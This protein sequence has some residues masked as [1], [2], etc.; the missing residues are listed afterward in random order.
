MKF[1]ID[2]EIELKETS[3]SLNGR[4]YVDALKEMIQNKPHDKPFTI[5]LFGEWG[6]GKSSIIKTVKTE[7][8]LDEKTKFITF[9]AWKYEDDAFRRSFILTLYDQLG[10]EVDPY[11]I[12]LYGHV[13]E[14]IETF[15]LKMPISVWLL[16]F[17][18]LVVSICLFVYN[19]SAAE[20]LNSL[21][22][23][24]IIL[25]YTANFG[26]L[27]KWVL[28]KKIIGEAISLLRQALLRKYKE[29]RPLFFSPEQF[30]GAFQKA[31]EKSKDRFN[32]IVVVV[33]NL[34]R[35]ERRYS[36]ELLGTIRGFLEDRNV[37]FV[38]PVD[39]NA[40]KKHIK[41]SFNEND[42]EA[43]EFLRKFFSVTLRIKP[44]K[45]QEIY[46]F[47]KGINRKHA[48]GFS[49]LTI[50][51]VSKEY[52]SNPRRIIQM[53]NNLSTEL[54]LFDEEFR[55]KFETVICKFLIIREEFPDYY[56]CLQRNPH[57]LLV[58][59]NE[60]LKL[61]GKPADDEL[62]G[63]INKT[64]V[65]TENVLI[66][67]ISRI[68][69]NSNVFATIPTDVVKYID[70]LRI[71]DLNS[72]IDSN[73][74]GAELIV[75]YIIAEMADHRDRNLLEYKFLNLLDVI[76]ELDERWKFSFSQNSRIEEILK[77]ILLHIINVRSSISKLANYGTSITSQGKRYIVDG[78]VK[79]INSE[80]ISGGLSDK[81][82]EVLLILLDTHRN[83]EDMFKQ[84]KDP[85]QHMY[86]INPSIVKTNT[87]NG[88]QLRIFFDTALI[89]FVIQSM[90]SLDEDDIS[91]IHYRDIV[92]K[93]DVAISL[94][95]QFL[96]KVE[97]LFPSFQNL[98]FDV[99][100]HTQRKINNAIDL[101]SGNLSGEEDTLRALSRRYDDNIEV[102][103]PY[104]TDQRVS[105]NYLQYTLDNQDGMEEILEFA[106]QIYRLSSGNVDMYDV[107]S[108]SISHESESIRE[109]A[110][111]SLRQMS[112]RYEPT[113]KPLSA[114]IL[115][116][117]ADSEDSCAL[118]S[119]ALTERVENWY[120]IDYESVRLKFVE[121]IGDV[122]DDLECSKFLPTFFEKVAF[123]Q[124]AR[125][126]L[127]EVVVPNYS[128]IVS[129][130]PTALQHLITNTILLEV[131]ISSYSDDFEFL[132][133][134]A[135]ISSPQ[136]R[137][138]LI[139]F[140]VSKLATGHEL[141][142]ALQIISRFKGLTTDEIQLFTNTLHVRDGH[143]LENSK[144]DEAMQVIG[145]IPIVF[146]K[147][148]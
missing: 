1:V 140:L 146:V 56:S 54:F 105:S 95:V 96:S 63:F 80:A 59:D 44:Y 144:I 78:L 37:A 64:K 52:A 50:D 29:E 93:C 40:L 53:F 51:L 86:H 143:S 4:V 145:N 16:L 138:K 112:D 142:Q 85:F 7:L 121:L 126:V 117:K 116:L 55:N 27:I 38:L 122:I 129:S 94:K 124:R 111:S 72:F 102:L 125:K 91:F 65:I 49:D 104:H 12:N 118:L 98:P 73:D 60:I 22:G 39:E 35:C 110:V 108:K 41:A 148:R 17:L 58:T 23:L 71:E 9:D 20:H 31:I 25:F 24:L 128:S 92:A 61:V 109:K 114:I 28:E 47:A 15:K 70:Y 57:N 88:V 18:F 48:L 87:L 99:V 97:T 76:S 147:I 30:Y 100:K 19:P 67:D 11:K 113:L 133:L 42:R 21:I 3:N 34:D 115:D 141:N 103:N 26:V 139:G 36:V 107:F 62:M 89:S 43:D 5:G 74:E 10:I 45:A 82:S 13:V 68:V 130:L 106:V 119:K 46:S 6:C 131:D 66:Q 135:E 137:E 69:S 75:D 120:I 136:H 77:P 83:D 33:D 32:L 90:H 123:D 8:E 81:W 2:E 84:L 134:L 132:K 79:I 14:E 127:V 101:I